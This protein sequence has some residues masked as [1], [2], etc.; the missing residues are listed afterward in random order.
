MGFVDEGPVFYYLILE[1]LMRI[2]LENCVLGSKNQMCQDVEIYI[3]NIFVFKNI[4]I[5]NRGLT[6][7]RGR[8]RNITPGEGASSLNQQPFIS[9]PPPPPRSRPPQGGCF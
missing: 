9:V 2:T 1:V 3:S 5:G 4:E 7:L 8:L 6:S